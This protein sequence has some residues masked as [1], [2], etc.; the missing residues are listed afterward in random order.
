MIVYHGATDII[1]KPDVFHSKRYLDFGKGFYI[2]F[3][4]TGTEMGSTKGNASRKTSDCK[5]LRID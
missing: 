5:C 2:T 1:K 4:R 3:L